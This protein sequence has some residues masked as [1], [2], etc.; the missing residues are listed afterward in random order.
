[1]SGRTRCALSLEGWEFL[2]AS[3]NLPDNGPTVLAS[4]Y[5]LY[6]QAEVEQALTVG[7]REPESKAQLGRVALASMATLLDLDA[8]YELAVGM[9]YAD[10]CAVSGD[11]ARARAR[12]QKM[13]T[14]VRRARPHREDVAEAIESRL[15]TGA[16]P[17]R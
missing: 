3:R 11:A 15:R 6:G 10:A 1:M 17:P 13:L 9:R 7:A 16:V 14:R 2:L 12:W 5:A 8:D 4:R